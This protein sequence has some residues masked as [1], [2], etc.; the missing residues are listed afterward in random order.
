MIVGL[1]FRLGAGRLVRSVLRIAILVAA[2]LLLVLA[3]RRSGERLGRLAERLETSEKNSMTFSGRC[4]KRRLAVLA[5]AASLPSGCGTAGSDRPA[6]A[7]CP[8]VVD[9]RA[10]L[11]VQAAFE[12]QAMPEGSAVETLLSD[13]AV[14]RD[15][16]RACTA[17]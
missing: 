10:K 15:Q 6:V 1:L 9:Y 3:C 14:M 13:Y 4:L 7:V 5:I 8:P 17:G 11:Q 12:L 16:A 2:I